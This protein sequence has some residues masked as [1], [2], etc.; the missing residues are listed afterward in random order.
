MHNSLT[1]S[2]SLLKPYVVKSLSLIAIILN[3]SSYIAVKS[4]LLSYDGI[5]A[6]KGK[7]ICCDL[8]SPSIEF[9]ELVKGFN[10]YGEK[11]ESPEEIKPVLKRALG[12]NK[13]VLLD[14]ILYPKERGF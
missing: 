7:F 4:A 10:V 5:C 8:S 14:I 11:I 1:A 3:N 9:V 13:P 12:L 6:H 2:K